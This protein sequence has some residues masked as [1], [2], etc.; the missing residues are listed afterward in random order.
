M[1]KTNQATRK[2]AATVPVQA[3][4]E[5]MRLYNGWLAYLLGRIGEREIRVEA[6]ELTRA[7]E[8]LSCRVEREGDAYV[9]RLTDG[10]GR[11]A[12][13]GA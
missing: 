2:P 8:T 13:D 7:L 11:D 12:R 9:I 6:A 5:V 1:K 10:E 3:V 4:D